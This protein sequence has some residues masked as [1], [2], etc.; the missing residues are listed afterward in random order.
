MTRFSYSKTLPRTIVSICSFIM[1]TDESQRLQSAGVEILRRLYQSDK[2]G[3]LGIYLDPQSIYLPIYLSI[4]PSV[5]VCFGEADKSEE[6]INLILWREFPRDISTAHHGAGKH[7]IPSVLAW[8]END[9]YFKV[10]WRC[11]V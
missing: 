9:R 8:F 2:K 1:K 11:R 5:F 3:D 10:V 4:H 6:T 7:S